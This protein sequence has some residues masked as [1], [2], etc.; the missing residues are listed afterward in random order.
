MYFCYFQR[1]FEKIGSET[2]DISKTWSFEF[3][4]WASYKNQISKI[5][6]KYMFYRKHPLQDAEHANMVSLS[7]K[8]RKKQYLSYV[9][10]LDIS[11]NIFGKWIDYK[12]ID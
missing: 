2:A 7:C 1:L 10:C 4:T 5:T 6:V 9:R 3:C 12:S 11:S 8:A